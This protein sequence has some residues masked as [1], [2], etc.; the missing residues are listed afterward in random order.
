MF[1]ASFPG[2][3]SMFVLESFMS[4][5]MASFEYLQVLSFLCCCC[6]KPGSH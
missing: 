4:V 5:V 2:K 3:V 6:V 1:S